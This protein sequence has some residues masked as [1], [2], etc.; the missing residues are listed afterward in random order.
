MR[1]CGKRGGAIAGAILLALVCGVC[2]GQDAAGSEADSG[3]RVEM[4]QLNF[5]PNMDIKLLVDYVSKRLGIKMLYDE[6]QL[7]KKITISA[8]TKV[9]LE[10]LPG[11]LESVLRMN[12][13]ALVEADVPGWKK[14]ITGQEMASSVGL[15]QRDPEAMATAE[16]TRVLAQYFQLEHAATNEVRQA[17]QGMLSKPGGNVFDIP[18][19]RTLIITDYA[20]RL[21]RI[22]EIIAL[23]DRPAAEVEMTFIGVEH[24]GAEQIVQEATKLLQEKARLAAAGRGS[25]QPD[26]TLSVTKTTNE[27]ILIAP[28][29]AGREAM[30]LIR[31]LDVPSEAVTETYTL[32]YVQ[33]QR[34]DRLAR[35]LVTAP[36]AEAAY[37][38]VIDAESGMLIVTAAPRVHERIAE[39][40]GKLDR[41]DVAEQQSRNVQF[42]KILNTTAAEVLATIQTL[43]GGG[44]I[45][46]AAV[47]GPAAG[48]G[49]PAS[50]K[51]DEGFSGPNE[52]PGRPGSELPKPPSY[53]PGE[54]EKK[55][56]EDGKDDAAADG[57]GP[58]RTTAAMG[59]AFLTADANTNTLIVVAPPAVQARYERLIK[60]LDKRR[61]QVMVEVTLVTLDTS[62]NFSLGVELGGSGDIGSGGEDRYVT[63]SSFGLAEPDVDTGALALSPGLGFNGVVISPDW[64]NV[65]I[66]ALADSGR[67]DVM[68]APRLL[69]NDNATATLSSV[70]EAPFTSINASDTVATTTF[71]GYASAGTTV[72]V[73]PHISEGNHLQLDYAVTLNS[74]TGEGSGSA[75][76]PRQTNELSSQVTIPNGHAIVIG[77]LTRKDFSESESK[78][79]F[80]GDIPLL[81]YLVSSRGRNRSQSTLFVFLR[82]VILRDDDF[83]DLKYL[84]EK[85][86]AAAKLPGN[87]P[88][89]TPMVMESR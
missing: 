66:R 16:P 32:Q 36:G 25:A 64:V 46:A 74:F 87:Y 12:G 85:D 67:S 61:P 27:V 35:E 14:I 28:R 11:L 39:L 41:R 76:P 8:A 49:K 26:Y 68:S 24:R 81:K 7:R 15:I 55:G 65:V 34:I 40:T 79:P 52:P 57:S 18:D 2:F 63:F 77:G 1:R 50:L 5:P 86:L 72:T 60:L 88:A 54:P 19:Q 69:V 71:A 10:S 82:P 51:R 53:E 59:D 30:D 47:A 62:N 33:P 6:G 43:E 31:R 29:G 23:L 13:L 58:S 38:S 56:K 20:D 22:A 21:R 48:A 44:A 84:S 83:A 70:A 78:I 17:I 80:L 3:D 9:P 45:E 42:Y 73:T 75:P 37:K 89:S 4:V